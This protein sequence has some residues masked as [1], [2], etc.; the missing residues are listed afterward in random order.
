MAAHVVYITKTDQKCLKA[1]PNE[2]FIHFRECINYSLWNITLH[3]DWSS[4]EL[5]YPDDGH[6]VR[7]LGL[8]FLSLYAGETYLYNKELLWCYWHLIF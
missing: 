7:K 1:F 2:C 5:F 4:F 8:T 3:K 6:V